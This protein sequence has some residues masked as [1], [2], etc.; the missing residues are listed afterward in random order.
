MY[1]SPKR[2]Y[3]RNRILGTT[4]QLNHVE[5]AQIHYSNKLRAPF[6][7]YLSGD[8]FLSIAQ[9]FWSLWRQ[10]S[11]LESW[12][13]SLSPLSA[14]PLSGSKNRAF[15][16]PGSC[17][18]NVWEFPGDA[19]HGKVYW[20]VLPGYILRLKLSFFLLTIL[21]KTKPK[22]KQSNQV[23]VTKQLLQQQDAK[24]ES[25]KEVIASFLI[26]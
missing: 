20:W 2:K 7:K 13:V 6:E 25:D 1:S 21:G 10:V 12:L 4:A 23:K 22:W 19:S 8:V 9:T 16:H 18:F 26:R 24:I 5:K 11:K 3:I 14:F 17:G 15:V